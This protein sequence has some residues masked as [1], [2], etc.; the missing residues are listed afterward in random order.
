MTT[1]SIKLTDP[2]NELTRRERRLLLVVCLIGLFFVLTGAIP[3]KIQALGIEFDKFDQQWFLFLFAAIVIYLLFLFVIYATS[4]YIKW[5]AAISDE[6][7]IN[8]RRELENSCTSGGGSIHEA[9]EEFSYLELQKNRFWFRLTQPTYMLRVLFEFI[10]PV[11]F[12]LATI[13]MLS[14]KASAL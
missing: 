9:M 1:H 6:I 3:K 7:K 5:K 12:S 10:V 11:L 8:Y 14:I 4:D 13:A 2:L